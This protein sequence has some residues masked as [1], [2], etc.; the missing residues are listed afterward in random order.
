[1]VVWSRKQTH[2][3][4]AFNYYKRNRWG[5]IEEF[6]MRVTGS[7]RNDIMIRQILEAVKI[8]RTDTNILMID[9]GKWNKTSLARAVIAAEQERL[10]FVITNDIVIYF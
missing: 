2:L 8:G 7:Y 3:L 6:G 10:Y 9:R 4:Y 1:M 5:E